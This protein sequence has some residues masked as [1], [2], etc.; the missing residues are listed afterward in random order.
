MRCNESRCGARAVSAQED[1]FLAIHWEYGSQLRSG[2][3]LLR[4]LRCTAVGT[5]V[6]PEKLI[7]SD[8]Q[9]WLHVPS[10][11]AAS[12]FPSIGAKADKVIARYLA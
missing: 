7:K 4:G 1:L 3:V 6:S 9:M 5:P 11:C 12:M 8:V 2:R 10:K